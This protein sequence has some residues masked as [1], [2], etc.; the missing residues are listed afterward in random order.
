M[1]IRSQS[2]PRPPG[3]RR[4]PPAPGQ[5]L[6][7]PAPAS[8]RKR[9]RRSGLR[10]APLGSP[11]RPRCGSAHPTRD[12]RGAQTGQR[13]PPD[14]PDRHRLGRAHAHVRRQ[15]RAEGALYLAAALGRGVLV[16]AL[17]RARRRLRPRLAQHQGRARRRPLRRQRPEGMDELRPHRPLRHPPGAHRSHRRP[18]TRASA[19]SS[20][21]WTPPASRYVRSST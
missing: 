14:Q 2:G 5:G 19:T 11:L 17:L 4:P 21:P 6:A 18:S 8:Q 10:R 15:R 12:R 1:R 7:A 16:P 13:P 20:A 9:P 3:R